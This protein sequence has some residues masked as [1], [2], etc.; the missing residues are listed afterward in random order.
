MLTILEYFLLAALIAV[1]VAISRW[2]GQQAYSWMPVQATAEAERVDA[3]FS[4]LTSVGAFIL[5]GIVSVI[6]YSVIF[7]RAV[8]RDFSEGHPMRGN[9]KLEI[10][11]IVVPS[12]FVLWISIQNINI[13]NQLNILGL[14]QIA[15]HLPLEQS[16]NASTSNDIPKPASEQIEVIAKQWVWSFRYKNNVTS[17][18]LHLPINQS[19][20]LLL[21]SQ[22]V[23]HGFYVPE[24]RLK[25]D[26]VPN[27]KIDLVITP[28]RLGKYRLK[29]SQFSGA[30]FAL[31]VADVYVENS[32][33]YDRWL[34]KV[35]T[36]PPEEVVAD[37]TSI[38]PLINS[39]WLKNS[40]KESIMAEGK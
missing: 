36:K 35:A 9:A 14:N 37:S 40:S 6:V 17:P 16:A 2:L 27:R 15:H 33:D 21:R 25:Q 11:W 32:Q 8:P 30:D 20:R 29:D 4:F 10:T 1:N 34:V 26:I 24:F 38:K 18:E 19:T 13:Y 22:D 23:I 39:G 28:N 12:L 5:I 7:F 3:L 31:M